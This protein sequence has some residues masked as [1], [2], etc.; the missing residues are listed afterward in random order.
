MSILRHDP[1]HDKPLNANWE[2]VHHG[3]APVLTLLVAGLAVPVLLSKGFVF[4]PVFGLI[5]A[6]LVSAWIVRPDASPW[7]RRL[8]GA[9]SAVVCLF[10]LAQLQRLFLGGT[11]YAHVTEFLVAK[12]RGLGRLPEDLESISFGARLLWQGPFETFNME[13]VFLAAPVSLLFAAAISRSQWYFSNT[14]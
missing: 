13:G 7:M 8:V 9:L 3:W 6:L 10:G 12:L 2:A 4:S 5:L 1:P 11:D 14:T